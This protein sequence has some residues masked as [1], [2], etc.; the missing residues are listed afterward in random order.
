M[1]KIKTFCNYEKFFYVKQK[2]RVFRDFQ[3]LSTWISIPITWIVNLCF[4]F[5]MDDGTIGELISF[6]LT[7]TEFR[8]IE[9]IS[10]QQL[11]Q[12]FPVLFL[13]NDTNVKN[14]HEL[15]SRDIE[16]TYYYF[17]TLKYLGVLNENV[18]GFSISLLIDWLINYPDGWKFLR[19][20]YY[21]ITLKFFTFLW[22]AR[23][24]RFW[25]NYIKSCYTCFKKTMQIG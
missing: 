14:W 11:G 13:S 16:P 20:Y 10:L 9:L 15:S 5:R 7:W 4:I 22:I 3:E 17:M 19:T 25:L 8:L 12:R 1:R 23:V 24:S 18:T 6:T 2:K 21:F